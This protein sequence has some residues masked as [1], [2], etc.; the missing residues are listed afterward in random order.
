[1]TAEQWYGI[2]RL[3]YPSRRPH[4]V[5]IN[6]PDPKSTTDYDC[7]LAI[8]TS[9]SLPIPVNLILRRRCG[10]NVNLFTYIHIK[11][12]CRFWPNFDVAWPVWVIFCNKLGT[13]RLNKNFPQEQFVM[14]GRHCPSET[15]SA[16]NTRNTCRNK[17]LNMKKKLKY[18]SISMS[19][20]FLM[21]FLNTTTSD[22]NMIHSKLFSTL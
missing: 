15:R 21:K 19:F 7:W 10:W 6:S 18:F 3:L 16:G 2:G 12:W 20:F 8:P 1:M 22:V 13:E 17:M 5:S 14:A 4:D 11:S 9:H